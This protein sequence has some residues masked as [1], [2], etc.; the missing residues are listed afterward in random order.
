[1]FT[2]Q[3]PDKCSCCLFPMC[4]LCYS[5]I[6]AAFYNLF[7]ENKHKWVILPSTTPYKRREIISTAAAHRPH[8]THLFHLFG[9]R[10]FQPHTWQPTD[11]PAVLV[12][13]FKIEQR[14]LSS[15]HMC[16]FIVA[17][18]APVT[19]WVHQFTAHM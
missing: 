17:I 15:S 3:R 16:D 8:S 2:G 6:F 19:S 9:Q 11:V 18:T 5:S 10:L 4:L 12:A 13:G 14:S 7:V 1:M